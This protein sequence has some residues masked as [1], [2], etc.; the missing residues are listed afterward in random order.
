MAQLADTFRK[1][2]EKNDKRFEQMEKQLSQITTTTS[3]LQKSD[4]TFP[5]LVN[6]NPK[7]GVHCLTLRIG[8]AVRIK[9]YAEGQ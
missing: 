7:L 3:K 9:A 2:E 5:S 8:C 4:G 6:Q 1:S